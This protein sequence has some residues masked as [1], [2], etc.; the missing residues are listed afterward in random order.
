[1][2]R[3][4]RYLLGTYLGKKQMGTETLR[5]KRVIETGWD[6]L[7]VPTPSIFDF[8]IQIRHFSKGRVLCLLAGLLVSSVP[9]KQLREG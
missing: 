6:E 5:E 8:Q 2:G 3:S 9:Q 4:H 7:S 1:M